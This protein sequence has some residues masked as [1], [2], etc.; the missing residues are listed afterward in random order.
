M[1][2][3]LELLSCLSKQFELSCTSLSLEFGI[4]GGLVTLVYSYIL[5][6][7]PPVYQVEMLCF[8]L[9]CILCVIPTELLMR[10]L[11]CMGD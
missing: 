2:C 9:I 1:C 8:A 3:V 6:L 7:S 4:T 5:S 11:S 10:P